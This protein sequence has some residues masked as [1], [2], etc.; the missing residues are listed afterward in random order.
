MLHLTKQII[1]EHLDLPE[2]KPFIGK[3]V[4]ITIQETPVTA[5]PNRWQALADIAGADLID[6]EVYRQQ[7]LQEAEL[8][9]ASN[10]DSR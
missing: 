10:H 8:M 1:S 2:L 4:E 5:T 7:R 6:P 9:R 3:Q